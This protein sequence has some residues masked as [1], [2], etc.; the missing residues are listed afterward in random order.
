MKWAKDTKTNKEICADDI[1]GKYSFV[2]RRYICPVCEKPV[3]YVSGFS[4]GSHFR[5]RHGTYSK[6]CENYVGGSGGGSYYGYYGGSNYGAAKSSATKG[7]S[8]FARILNGNPEFFFGITFSAYEITAYEKEGAKLRLKPNAV[9][10][11]S[12]YDSFSNISHENFL[13][14]KE[15]PVRLDELVKSYNLQIGSHNETISFLNEVTFF[16][17]DNDEEKWFLSDDIKAIKVQTTKIYLNNG[18]VCLS[19]KT[20]FNIR[21]INIYKKINCANGYIAYFLDITEA[22]DECVKFLQN[23]GYTLCGERDRIQILWPP[24]AISDGN[25]VSNSDEIFVKTNFILNVDNNINTDKYANLNGGLYKIHTD[26]DILFK[27]EEMFFEIKREIAEPHLLAELNIENNHSDTYVS[28]E[29]T[30]AFLFSNCGIEKIAEGK[31]VP[32]FDGREV[33]EYISNYIIRSITASKILSD[34]TDTISEV[35]K[36]SKYE[37]PF[38]A[39]SIP[40]EGDNP[41]IIN[42]LRRCREKKKINGAVKRLL[43]EGAL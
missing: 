6:D 7:Y 21:G 30:S 8:I 9:F 38:R 15:Y 33:K 2:Q 31:S 32:L 17:A 27:L 39:D 20:N 37:E 42:Y 13:A 40:Y 1:D 43:C 3:T 14:D 4:M 22:T 29:A 24:A 5:H 34:Y 12:Y 28:K 25:F 41:F 23:Q 18:Y 35:L 26:S 16:N 11:P 19:N 36:Y 10:L